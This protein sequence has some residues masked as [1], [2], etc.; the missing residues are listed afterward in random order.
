MHFSRATWVLR[1]IVNR[2]VLKYGLRAIE[3]RTLKCD[4]SNEKKWKSQHSGQ[5]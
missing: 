4:H 2:M 1:T 3:N 5:N